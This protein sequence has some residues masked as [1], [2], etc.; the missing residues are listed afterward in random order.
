[1]GVLN[2]V[3]YED[4]CVAIPTDDG[5]YVKI[6]HF[7][8]AKYYY[9]YVMRNGSWI[10]R[11]KVANP[12]TGMHELDENESGKREKIFLLNKACSHIAAVFFGKGGEEFMREKG[13]SIVKVPP[14]TTVDDVLKRIPLEQT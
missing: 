3:G 1:M 4:L 5:N 9:H 11:K 10:L 13:F 12:Y 7:G 8:D 14:K 2:S 6:G